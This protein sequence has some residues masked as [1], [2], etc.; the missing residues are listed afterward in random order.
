M[1]K[2]N[3]LRIQVDS[4]IIRVEQGII[5]NTIIINNMETIQ[6]HIFFRL[7]NVNKN[8]SGMTF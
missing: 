5:L 3:P 4:L 8:S 1:T 6:K 7:I 2:I